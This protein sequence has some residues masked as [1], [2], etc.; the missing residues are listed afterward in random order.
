M[1]ASME[2]EKELWPL[3]SALPLLS[4]AFLPD[5]FRSTDGSLVVMTRQESR[6]AAASA[7]IG[8]A[9]LLGGA[10]ITAFL[11]PSALPFCVCA[12]I[13][14]F[15][16]GT[17]AALR[18]ARVDDIVFAHRPTWRAPNPPLVRATG[19]DRVKAGDTRAFGI[20]SA[21]LRTSFAPARDNGSGAM[22]NMTRQQNRRGS[23]KGAV[24][25]VAFA[26]AALI[27]A[28]AL[29][30]PGG[31]SSGA[32]LAIGIAAYIAVI[33]LLRSAMLAWREDWDGLFALRGPR[34]APRPRAASEEKTAPTS[35]TASGKPGPRRIPDRAPGARHG[36]RIASVLA[37]AILVPVAGRAQ[38][39]IFNV[40]SADV[41]DKG[42]LYLEEDTLWRPSDPNFAVFTIRGVYGFGSA[43][44]GGVNVGGFVTP[45]RSTPTATVALKWQPIKSGGFALTTGAHGLF[46]L[47]GS[48]D[49]DPAGQFY[50][51]VSYAFPT[52]TRVTAGGWVATSGYAAAD[53]RAGGLFSLEQKIN[54]HLTLAA[55]WFTGHNGI[56]YLTPG[57]VSAWGKWTIYAAYTIKNGDSKGNAALIELGYSF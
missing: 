57:I 40:P 9:G 3:P 43:I 27:F 45:G 10:A 13:A 35:L 49:G 20:L 48:E 33:A 8:V 19:D 29:M 34:R 24:V 47:R 53:D 17:R 46:F 41:L 36:I 1:D 37:A 12:G 38:Q 54:D 42:K 22:K 26:V 32:R 51:H 18:I 25:R 52:N 16:L 39:T 7:A 4:F 50:A 28:A 15:V 21:S 2:R 5:F 14:V 30:S 44:E 31:L 56:G 23:R 11:A 55:D 6:K